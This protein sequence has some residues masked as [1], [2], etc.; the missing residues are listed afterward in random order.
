[1]DKK[2]QRALGRN[3]KRL[4]TNIDLSKATHE[5]FGQVVVDSI[6]NYLNWALALDDGSTL[7][8]SIYSANLRESAAFS[9]R[10]ARITY[11]LGKVS[12]LDAAGRKG[13]VRAQII[14]YGAIAE[15]ILLD[16]I[17]CIGMQN[18]P[19]G[20][21][22]AVDKVGQPMPWTDD[23]LFTLRAA[24]TTSLRYQYDL[25]WLISQA[26]R[27]GAIDVNLKRR[28]DWLR[29]SRN[30]VHPVIPTSQRYTDDLDSGRQARNAVVDVRDASIAFKAAV[31]L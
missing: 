21:R 9:A 3:A 25:N 16:L 12:L 22:P 27:V 6:Q 14:E 4:S 19:I 2:I 24:N 31:G 8:N 1:M 15:A 28:L 18:K 5:N 20:L 29:K 10:S 13:L 23:G 17:Q 26:R 7:V 11:L 30:L